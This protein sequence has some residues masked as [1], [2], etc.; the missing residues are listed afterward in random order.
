MKVYGISPQVV[1]PQ[2]K[3]KVQQQGVPTIQQSNFIQP[4]QD[5]QP[6]LLIYS[7]STNSEAS[8]ITCAYENA[9]V[10]SFGYKS[11]LK[12]LFRQGEIPS[13]TRGLYGNKIDN[14]TVSIEHLLPHSLGGK[15]TLSN[16]A[17]AHVQA[18]VARGS[19]PLPYFLD[20]KM[21]DD[22]LSQFNFEIKG[23]FNGYAYQD[24]IR[25]TCKELGVGIKK[26][27]A[28]DLVIVEKFTP[29]PIIDMG[30]MKEVIAHLDDINLNELP[31]KMLRSL[32]NRGYIK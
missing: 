32:K 4:I 1:R 6:P 29:F 21:L 26:L 20:S 8:K 19:N 25:K 7:Y 17:L 30:N 5:S 15:D 14:S 24:M 13:V 10:I 11:I 16:Y 23:R 31:K 12:D 9:Q 3:T 27:E 2:C 28:S 18:N 22:Y